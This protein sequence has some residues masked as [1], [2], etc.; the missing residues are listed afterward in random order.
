MKDKCN[1]MRFLTNDEN[2]TETSRRKA[3]EMLKTCLLICWMPQ[4]RLG[5]TISVL[6]L[7]H[8]LN[9]CIYA[10]KVQTPQFLLIK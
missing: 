7:K 8:F 9:Y 5:L 10:I 3:A 1:D 4:E 2:N 6:D